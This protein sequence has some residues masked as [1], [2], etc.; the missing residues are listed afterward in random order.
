MEIRDERP[1]P[2]SWFEHEIIDHYAHDMGP[3]GVSVYMALLRFCG[4]NQTCY[5]SYETIESRLGLSHQSVWRGIQKLVE[6]KLISVEQRMSGPK[7]RASN[8]YTIQRPSR[9]A[10][11][12][13]E[14]LVPSGNKP[15]L[16]KDK[17]K[18]E[19]SSLQ[20]HTGTIFTEVSSLQEHT[21]RGKFPTGTYIPNV[22]ESLMNH[23][24]ISQEIDEVSSLQEHTVSSLRELEVDTT[25]TKA[26]DKDSNTRSPSALDIRFAIFW[27]AYPKKMAK[28]KALKVWT[29]IK[30]S[31]ELLQTMLASLDQQ[32]RS[33]NWLDQQ[34][35]FIPWPAKWLD[36]ERWED[37]E[38]SPP[39]REPKFQE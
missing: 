3:I 17:N 7:G 2:W 26:K 22:T 6:L 35:K 33:D 19:V 15:K 1:Q 30:P 37:I 32:K 24:K 5:P 21:D 13:D 36:E 11:V 18:Y 23:V 29:R 34:G 31:E 8:I 16:P 20:E 38:Y 28:G 25:K 14:Q 4:P 39:P 9:C 12:S 27:K 10:I